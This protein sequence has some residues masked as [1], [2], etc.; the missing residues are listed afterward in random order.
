MKKKLSYQSILPLLDQKKAKTFFSSKKE[1]EKTL[2][3]A[4]HELL[5]LQ[6]KI[7][8]NKKKVIL[9]F[10]GADAAGKGGVIRRLAEHLD[11]RGLKVHA[12]GAPNVLEKDQ[13]YFERFFKKLPQAG[14][15]CVFDRSWYGRVLVERVE[16]LIQKPDW[17]RAYSEI[18]A[19]EK[20][21]IQDGVLISKY[22]LDLTHDEQ[23]KR[24]EERRKNP[25]KAWKL[26]EEDLRNRNKW[27]EYSL[28]I[29]EMIRYTSPKISPWKVLPADS[30]WYCRVTI[31][32]DLIKKLKRIL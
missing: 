15:I 21:W 30:K 18:N 2:L 9:V 13:N 22:Y 19:I 16:K 6:Q 32:N 17:V 26:T 4:Q 5:V 12:I 7:Y 27:N 29:K 25:L 11:P 3:K 20:M 10:E 28:A 8:Q 31:M 14:E 24:F 1:Y 23:L